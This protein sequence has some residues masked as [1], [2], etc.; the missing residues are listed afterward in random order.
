MT[1][2]ENARTTVHQRKQI[3]HSRAPYRVLAQALGVSVAT[4]ERRRYLATAPDQSS[5]PQRQYKALPL[6]AAPL[7]G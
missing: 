1:D 6:E 3:R 2:H 7:L 5:C 4:V